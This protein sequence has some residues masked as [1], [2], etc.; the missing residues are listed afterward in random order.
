MATT[1]SKTIKLKKSGN[2]YNLGE[3]RAFGEKLIANLGESIFN[4]PTKQDFLFQIF[5]QISP[6]NKNLEKNDISIE[7]AAN[8]VLEALHLNTKSIV[9]LLGSEESE[10]IKVLNKS[11]SDKFCEIVIGIDKVPAEA[12]KLISLKVNEDL[13]SISEL[14]KWYELQTPIEKY[15]KDEEV[16][17]N[18][19]DRI[20]YDFYKR[21]L[22]ERVEILNYQLYKLK[23]R[24]LAKSRYTPTWIAQM[25]AFSDMFEDRPYHFARPFSV[26]YFDC[27]KIDLSGHRVSDFSI[28]EA[29]QLQK[30]YIDNKVNFY[31]SYFKRITVQQHFQNFNFFLQQLPLSKN[32]NLIFDELIRL[33]KAKR[34]I[35]FYALALPQVE[36]LFSEMC[37][38]VSP[39]K[40]LSQKSLTHKVNSIRPFHALSRSYFDYYQYYIPLQRN[41]FSHTGYDEDFKLKSFDLLVDLSHL[42]QVFHELDNPLV[43]VKKLHSRRNPEDFITLREFVDYFKL[44]KELKPLQKKEINEDIEKFEKEFL[45]LDCGIDYICYEIL[46]ELPKH[47]EKF[48]N[49]FNTRFETNHLSIKFEKLDFTDVNNMF[50]IKT[51][52]EIIFDC[53]YSEF[54]TVER[55]ETYSYFINGYEKFLPSLHPEI[56]NEINKLKTKY[57]SILKT[58]TQIATEMQKRN[59]LL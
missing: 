17:K 13:K 10:E 57:N 27:R 1:L 47:L 38:A 39:D 9:K 52:S 54:Q 34:W 32:R 35:S 50:K 16:P 4:L 41:R 3:V 19:A 45:I 44:V 43:K 29:S 40:D 26:N 20:T 48:L 15:I 12:F 7:R 25:F 55:L 30:L 2:R 23:D 33:F 22:K 36:G 24:A 21:C 5:K 42:L 46:Q 6:I 18:H 53:F 58:I 59:I 31:K 49:S 14:I 56:K 8:K 51:Q 37:N 28:G 11:N